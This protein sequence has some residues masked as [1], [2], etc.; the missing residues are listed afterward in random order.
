MLLP[1]SNGIYSESDTGSTTGCYTHQGGTPSTTGRPINQSVDSSRS[2][3]LELWSPPLFST[4]SLSRGMPRCQVIR[5][6]IVS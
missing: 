2:L 4:H 5:V 6:L 3:F 1:D